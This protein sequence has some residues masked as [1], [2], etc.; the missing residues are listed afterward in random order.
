MA[1]AAG[2]SP[3]IAAIGAKPRTNA[4][5]EFTHSAVVAKAWKALLEPSEKLDL[6]GGGTIEEVAAR[7]ADAVDARLMPGRDR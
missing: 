2:D 4:A 5:K 6:D 3:S 1:E 7:V